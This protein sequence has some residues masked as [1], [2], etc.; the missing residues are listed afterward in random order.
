MAHNPLVGYVTS[1]Y[2]PR[3]VHPVTGQVTVHA[4][5][6]IASGTGRGVVR[7]MY[8]GVVFRT[9][10]GVFA[11]RSGQQIG[12]RNPDG[13]VQI[14]GHLQRIDVRVGQRV[15]AGQ[16][17]G[18]EGATGNVTGPHLHF[19]CHYRTSSDRNGWARHRNPRLDFIAA[20]ITPGS[21]IRTSTSTS[22][23]STPGGV[24]V[25]RPA[26]TASQLKSHHERQGVY[27]QE[28]R[29]LISR[30]EDR[31][32]AIEDRVARTATAAQ[33]NAVYQRVRPSDLKNLVTEALKE[34]N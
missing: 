6:D 32:D 17:L 26:A 21:D 9:G 11:H 14:Y 19:E 8:G 3:R 16:A 1:E 2:S 15:A 7:A 20:G 30:L 34:F 28:L 24:T 12:I 25:S 29:D 22:T 10:W 27:Q 23:T 5:I 13:E 31:L 4:G 33:A 18:I